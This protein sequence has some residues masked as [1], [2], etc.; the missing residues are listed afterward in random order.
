MRTEKGIYVFEKVKEVKF[1]AANFEKV[2]ERVT[3][4]YKNQK[5]IEEMKKL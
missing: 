5:L 2:K 3:F 4:D 1:E